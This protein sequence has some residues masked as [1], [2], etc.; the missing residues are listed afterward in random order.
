VIEINI[1]SWNTDEF[2][3]KSLAAFI[4]E[5]QEIL[6]SH[7]Q[8]NEISITLEQN[9]DR[10]DGYSEANLVIRRPETEDEKCQREDMT[11][12]RALAR[13]Q[14]EARKRAELY[15]ALKAEFEK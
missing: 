1:E 15:Q 6:D 5:L 12:K 10:W 4:L 2:G 9:G 11:N 3:E 14:E 8:S 7:D 13:Q